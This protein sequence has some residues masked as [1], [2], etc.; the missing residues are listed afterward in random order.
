MGHI[1]K[2]FCFRTICIFCGS[3]GLFQCLTRFNLC[4]LLLCHVHGCQQYF[5]QFSILPF[6]RNIRSNFIS[7]FIQAAILKLINIIFI[8]Q[9]L[10][11]IF[12]CCQDIHRFQWFQ[13]LI[14]FKNLY[15]EIMIKSQRFIYH[16]S[17]Q[18]IE[19]ISV[20]FQIT[21]N[22]A[23]NQTHYALDQ[24]L[25]GSIIRCHLQMPCALLTSISAGVQI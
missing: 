14:L 3:V 25:H 6:Q 5:Y 21:D 23:V 2:E 19:F 9:I 7:F 11:D 16:L 12:R 1:G 8:F 13:C 24:L 10:L 18:I 20:I 17:I 22:K 4:F 15:P